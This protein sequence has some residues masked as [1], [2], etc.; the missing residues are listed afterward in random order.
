[1]GLSFINPVFKRL[2]LVRL[3]HQSPVAIRGTAGYCQRVILSGQLVFKKT[4]D[5]TRPTACWYR[6][7][8]PMRH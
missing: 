7:L 3:A 5:K 8:K 1:V 2:P 4:R 6:S